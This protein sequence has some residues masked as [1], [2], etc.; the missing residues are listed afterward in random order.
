M[1]RLV[2]GGDLGS[3]MAEA[4]LVRDWKKLVHIFARVG[5][6]NGN[7]CERN[8][9]VVGTAVVVVGDKVVIAVGS[10]TVTEVA[11]KIAGGGLVFLDRPAGSL[12]LLCLEEEEDEGGM[13]VIYRRK[14][15]PS[16][17]ANY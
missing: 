5:E 12:L 15:C 4:N 6:V 10:S 9:V 2:G 17:E 3:D 14:V 1:S 13:M 7:E 8:E 16:R 11:G